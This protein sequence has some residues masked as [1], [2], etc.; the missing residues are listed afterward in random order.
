MSGGWQVWPGQV[1][2]F[3][4]AV[5]Q[6]RD[7]LNTV[8][9]QVDQLT[10][11]AYQAQLGNSPVGQALATKFSDRL[12]GGEGLLSQLNTVLTNLDQFVSA[13]EQTASRYADADAAAAK[14]LGTL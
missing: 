11:P 13:A 7:D 4:N 2:A 10:S 6:V 9:Q 14:Q 3:A 8:F 5:A 12:S 1:T